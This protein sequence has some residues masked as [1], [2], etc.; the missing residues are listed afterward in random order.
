M[1]ASRLLFF[2]IL[3]AAL[4]ATAQ[5]V[6]SIVGTQVDPATAAVNTSTNTVFVANNCGTDA[7]CSVGTNPSVTVINGATLSTQT[8][9][10]GYWP[11]G[12]AVDSGL[13]QAYTATCASDSTCLSL[14]GV[15]AIN[16]S[17]LV[18]TNIASTGY[19]TFW[20][21]VNPSTHNVYAV[22]YCDDPNYPT[23]TTLG[24]V[25]VIN[26]TTLKSVATVQAGAFP[27]SA[28]V[29]TATNM[30]YVVNQCGADLTC[31]SAGSVTVINGSTNKIV[32]TIAVD[33]YPLYAAIDQ[34]NNK[35]YVTNNGGTDGTYTNGT[36][37]VIDGA[38]N[39]VE[40]D[41]AVGLSPSPVVFNPNTNIV[42]VGN[43]CG[44]D[45]NCVLPPSVTVI[46]GSNNMVT[47]AVSICTTLTQPADDSELDVNT[48]MVYFPCQARPNQT[49]ATG[50]S[51]NVL[52]GA[53]NTAFP[54]A[55]G[56]YPNAAV[57]NAKTNTIYV[58]NDGD[59]TVSV[60]GATTKAQLNNVTPCRLVDTRPGS[61][62]SGPIQGGK[63]E[64]FNL[65]QLAQKKCTGLNLSSAI[66]YSL[67]VTLVPSNRPVGYLTIWPDS[68]IQP[69]VS[70]MNSD[71]RIKANAAIVSAGLNGAVDVYVANTANI[72]LDIDGYFG[73]SGS[74]TLQYYPLTP[75][76][77]ADTRSSKEP[78]GLGAPSLA[79][80][81]P[82]SFPLL[83]ATTCFQQVHSGV[84]VAAY[85]LNFTAV[86][87]G[88]LGYLTIWPTGEP[89][90]TVSTLNAPTG[91]VTANA[92]IV[93]AGTSGQIS[94]YAY[95]AS[96]LI[97]DIDGYFAA[98]GTGG[99]S[100]Y[101]TAPC[102]VLDTRPPNGN[103]P[104]TGTLSPPVNVLASPC[105]V[106]S[107]VPPASLGYNFNATV[108]PY[109]GG[110]L[111][112]LTLWPAGENQPVVSTLNAYDGAITSNM[113][114]VPAGTN[115]EINAYAGFG[116][117]NLILDISGFYAP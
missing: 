106:P 8:V 98:P 70:T 67:N 68:L 13:N 33:F 24:N 35:I 30:I 105:S 31:Q 56:D 112:Y 40:A 89:Q 64:A 39:T 7:G 45:P 88:P 46:N 12:V 2:V 60:I 114:I 83:N 19:Q 6:T 41:I 72:I 77:I 74:S 3:V 95:N 34:V 100:L 87:H 75:C 14:G 57:V 1:R 52:N 42:Y 113:A 37:S 15:S 5:V 115:G 71:G 117:T 91:A 76:R 18:V 49:L 20:I 69:G 66:S 59:D 92:A 43:Q 78:P 51:V 94:A 93:P 108:V 85:S 10:V 104:F 111:G 50:L 73:P 17:T 38:T 25:T 82:R 107:S 109:Q 58:P 65:P 53:N 86:P 55:V 84:N 4:P 27:F 79:A 81:Q 61:G 99:L 16:G 29:N 103:G 90:P 44:S 32:A 9:Q 97:I 102:R 116:T 96:D 22:N 28:A 63:Y 26:G 110:S 80:Q 48:N 36:V 21:A 11:Y 101:P 54:V 47:T 23:C 62:G